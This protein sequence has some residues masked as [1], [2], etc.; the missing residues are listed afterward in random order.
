MLIFYHPSSAGIG[1]I[2]A[3][4]SLGAMIPPSV[5]LIIC[6]LVTKTSI[7]ALFTA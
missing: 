1:A 7:T 6:G 4:G 5:V 2:C 3:G